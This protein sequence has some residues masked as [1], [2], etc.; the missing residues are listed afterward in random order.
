MIAWI[1]ALVAAFFV[2]AYFGAPLLGW[3]LAGGAMLAW[4]SLLFDFS[5]V[6]N[7]ALFALFAV[8]AVAFNVAPLRRMFFTNRVLAVFRRILPDMSPTEKEAIDAG[9]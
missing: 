8:A 5:F 9:T 6:T 1:L 2:L 4:L 7:T 3:T